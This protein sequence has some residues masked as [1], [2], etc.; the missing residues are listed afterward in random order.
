MTRRFGVLEAAVSVA[1]LL[2]IAAVYMALLYAPDPSNLTTEVTRKAQ[3]IFYFHMGMNVMTGLAFLVNFLSSITYLLTRRN[4]WDVMARSAA[5]LGVVFG[6]GVLASGSLWARP[7]WN[8]WWTWDPRLTT[9]TIT[10]LLYVAYLMLRSAVEDPGRRARFAAVYGM[11]AFVSVPITFFSIRWWRTIHPTVFGG[12]NAS[13]QGGFTLGPT[14]RQTL[15]FMM[16]TFTVM[17]VV[18]LAVRVRVALLEER[19]SLLRERAIVRLSRGAEAETVQVEGG[20]S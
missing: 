16:V 13:A 1:G 17:F 11:F 19:V 15:M 7:T 12:G 3:H 20:V 8:A 18:T 14:I 6:V 4:F 9:A 5:E 10:I 2:V